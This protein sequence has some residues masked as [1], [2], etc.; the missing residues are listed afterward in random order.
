MKCKGCKKKIERVLIYSDCWQFGMLRGNR[1]V[2]FGS[3]EE[4]MNT[5]S[6]ECPECNEDLTKEVQ[7]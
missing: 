4:V 3:V 6:I 5:T 1:I 2:E 7:L